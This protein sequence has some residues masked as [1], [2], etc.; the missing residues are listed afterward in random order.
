MFTIANPF[1]HFVNSIVSFV[2]NPTLLF[3]TKPLV[4]FVSPFVFFLVNPL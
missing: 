2:V 3:V 4:S 1:M